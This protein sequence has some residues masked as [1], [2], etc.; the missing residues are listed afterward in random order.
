MVGVGVGGGGGVVVVVGGGGTKSA[1]R[2]HELTTSCKNHSLCEQVLFV[3]FTI[4]PP[5]LTDQ[6]NFITV[7]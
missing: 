5:R 3:R 4:I 1:D 7:L 6:C 2:G